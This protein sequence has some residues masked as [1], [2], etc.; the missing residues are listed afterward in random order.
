MEPL[1]SKLFHVKPALAWKK[2]VEASGYRFDEE[3]LQRLLRYR[4]WLGEEAI[5]AG[6]LGPDENSRLD[7][8]H[9]A[10]SLLFGTV[11]E[12]TDSIVDVG[13]GVGLPGIPLAI[14]RDTVS[15]LLVDRSGRRV[16]LIR[17]A[18]RILKLSN[19]EVA[20]EDFAH[21]DR[22]ESTVVSRATLPPD[23]FRPI[24]D[25]VLIPGG[26]A[27]LGGS[28]TK[29]PRHAGYETKEIGSEILEQP[30]WILMMRKT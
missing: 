30:V 8:R 3:K 5:G 12:P 11:L 1:G 25:R 6:G 28:W 18:I 7:L 27:V 15:F 19:V 24:L 16:D 14:I 26:Q 10:D 20:Q 9:I 13:S 4:D 2:V 22:P 21:W 23:R 17:R 29:R